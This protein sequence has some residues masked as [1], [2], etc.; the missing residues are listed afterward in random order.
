MADAAVP[1]SVIGLM[2]ALSYPKRFVVE[3]PASTS[4]YGG[5][6]FGG[7]GGLVD[8]SPFIVDPYSTRR[9][10][11]TRAAVVEAGAPR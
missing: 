11:A 2:V 4:Q 6:I 3:H 5:G 9:R 10:A 7:Y 1:A 8:S